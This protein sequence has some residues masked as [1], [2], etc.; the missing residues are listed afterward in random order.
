MCDFRVLEKSK[1]LMF[2]RFALVLGERPAPLAK[3]AL[4][5]LLV[6]HSV[7]LKSAC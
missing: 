7:D 6:Y 3:S 5:H 2:R 1:S 4:G